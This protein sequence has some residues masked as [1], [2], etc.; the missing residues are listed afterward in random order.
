M[1]K[2][3]LYNPDLYMGSEL[4]ASTNVI[5]ITKALTLVYAL[6]TFVFNLFIR[7]CSTNQMCSPNKDV[8]FVSVLF[9]IL[10]SVLMIIITYELVRK[11]LVL[12]KKLGKSNFWISEEIVRKIKLYNWT[13]ISI[14]ITDIISV[15]I[16][17]YLIKTGNTETPLTPEERKTMQDIC[18]LILMINLYINS[19]LIAKCSPL[20]AVSVFH[21][22]VY[23]EPNWEA[24]KKLEDTSNFDD[25]PVGAD[26]RTLNDITMTNTMQNARRLFKYKNDQGQAM[27]LTT[28]RHGGSKREIVDARRRGIPPPQV[29]Y[30][31]SS[32]EDE[33]SS[34]GIPLVFPEEFLENN[35]ELR[36]AVEFNQKRQ[37][38]TATSEGSAICIAETSD[39]GASIELSAAE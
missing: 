38:Q 28:I 16:G 4:K 18:V 2:L 10:S 27:F 37:A 21:L 5:Q 9:L 26:A 32:Q 13:S 22:L 30:D 14:I 29:V 12:K 34:S 35:P 15:L 3:D 24:E 23:A 36:E 25:L 7:D 20:R 17:V 8:G 1:N 39:G 33:S 31:Y 19:F 6:S 11:S